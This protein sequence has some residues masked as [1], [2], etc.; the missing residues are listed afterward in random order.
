[1]Q[2][3]ATDEE[4]VRAL[5]MHLSSTGP[6]D[7]PDA[8]WTPD[9]YFIRPSGNPLSLADLVSGC[10]GIDIRHQE[11]WSLDD[12]RFLGSR[13]DACVVTA[14]FRQCFSFNGCDND[15]VANNTIVLEKHG[16]DWKVVRWQRST[17]CAPNVATA[18]HG[19][20]QGLG[21]R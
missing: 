21:Q 6:G 16:G 2:I 7:N 4:K 11:L 18:P 14:K 9:G 12:I 13:G 17:G 15:D 19:G 3:M 10:P 8:V 1:M 5:V 20:C